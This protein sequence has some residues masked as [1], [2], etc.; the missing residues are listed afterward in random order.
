MFKGVLRKLENL[1]PFRAHFCQK[2]Q[3]V[4]IHINIFF[5]IFR[6]YALTWR[7]WSLPALSH[8][9]FLPCQALLRF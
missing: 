8:V 2:I 5:S 6:V 7:I 9:Y 4:S 3:W 1:R